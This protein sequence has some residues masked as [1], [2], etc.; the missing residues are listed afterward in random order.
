MEQMN[1]IEIRGNVGNVSIFTVGES[2]VA[3]FSVA[4]NFAYKDKK[5]EPVIETMWHNV[6]AWEGKSI[7]DLS[8]IERGFPIYVC[9]RMRAQRFT[10][11]DGTE[12]ISYEILANA[13]ERVEGNLVTQING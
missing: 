1:R 9:G 10:G 7:P 2:K 11:S 12:R 8:I 3:H 4:T 5:N 13:V 6:T